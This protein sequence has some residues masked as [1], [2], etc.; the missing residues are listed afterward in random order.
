[1]TTTSDNSYGLETEIKSIDTRCPLTPSFDL[2]KVVKARAVGKQV[3][4]YICCGPH[5]PYANMFIE[6]PG[7]SWGT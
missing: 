7:C 2:K 5:H 6:Y 1:M 4:W 3:W